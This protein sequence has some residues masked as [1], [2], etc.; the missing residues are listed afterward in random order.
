MGRQRE[1]GGEELNNFSRKRGV[2][3]RKRNGR[4]RSKKLNKKQK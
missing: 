4:C 2:G 3:G 1:G